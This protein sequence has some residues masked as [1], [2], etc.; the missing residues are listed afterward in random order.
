MDKAGAS[1]IVLVSGGVLVTLA[2]LT[3]NDGSRYKR[4]WAAGLLTAGLGVAADFVPE[5]VAPF[6]V[7][8]I[9]AAVVKNPGVI[10]KFTTGT[11]SSSSTVTPTAA[12]ASSPAGPAAGK[13][14][15]NAATAVSTGIGGF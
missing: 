2:L 5:I 11:T 4:I 9:I 13:A 6:A 7:L 10:G 14:A 3:P 12:Q 1:T 15:G 8:V